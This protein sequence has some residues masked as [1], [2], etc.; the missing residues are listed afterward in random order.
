MIG[1]DPAL[2]A[3]V[4]A[5]PEVEKAI[6]DLANRHGQNIQMALAGPNEFGIEPGS[7][8]VRAADGTVLALIDPDG[9]V[10]NLW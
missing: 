3:H 7:V 8:F 9:E 6:H 1:P 5:H 10:E 4:T 2:V